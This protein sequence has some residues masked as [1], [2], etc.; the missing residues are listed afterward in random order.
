MKTKSHIALEGTH[1]G[2][3]V[4]GLLLWTEGMP[5]GAFVGKTGIFQSIPNHSEE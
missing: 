5:S 2:D 4:G 1:D 3:V